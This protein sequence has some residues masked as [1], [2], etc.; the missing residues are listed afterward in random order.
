MLLAQAV[1]FAQLA[2]VP[3]VSGLYTAAMPMLVYS[4]LASSNK[5]SSTCVACVRECVFACG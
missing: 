5:V 1:A 3:P 4:A 2:G